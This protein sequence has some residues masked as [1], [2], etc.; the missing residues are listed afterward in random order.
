MK[1]LFGMFGKDYNK[2]KH[3]KTRRGKLFV[4]KKLKVVFAEIIF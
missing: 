2:T 3:H 1:I 4:M